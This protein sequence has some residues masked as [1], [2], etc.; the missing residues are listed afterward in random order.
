MTLFIAPLLLLGALY[1]LILSITYHPKKIESEIVECSEQA[2][3]LHGNEELKILSWNVQY[4]ASKN[5][6][7]FYD[8][9]AGGGKN[10]M[11]S[12]VDVQKTLTRVAE[13]I[14][15]E[16]PDIILLQEVDKNSKRTYYMDQ[17]KELQK[18]LKN[19]YPCTSQSYYWKSKFVPHPKVLGSVGMT[20][21]ILSKYKI[22][23]SNRI[24]LPE[25]PAD[26]V[27][28]AFNIK[29]AVQQTVFEMQGDKELHIMN[30]HLSAFAQKTDTMKLQI[31]MI[32]ELLKEKNKKNI[33][34]LI[35]G[36][37]NLLAPNVKLETLIPEERISYN[38]VTEI[39]PL[40]NNYKVRPALIDLNGND[41]QRFFTFYPNNQ[42]ING[43]DRAID[44]IFHSDLLKVKDFK[45]MQKNTQDISD[46]L[47]LIIKIKL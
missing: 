31:E 13:V 11:P 19:K 32:D 40:F 16:N 43:P 39:L 33:P 28:K 17:L 20:L 47:P 26:P 5:Y 18:Q 21:T 46:H 4:L 27:T 44:Y 42:K 14:N 45:V 35:A 7:F 30:T 12:L 3:I 25:I 29:R 1:L 37:F 23:T 24:A 15:Q 9:P 38:E 6:V 2:P 8:P 22:S 41:Q 36:D 10:T 34:W